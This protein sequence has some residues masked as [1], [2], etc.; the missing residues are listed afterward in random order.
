MPTN[1]EN[2]IESS[3]FF[4]VFE[5][6]FSS[7]ELQLLTRLQKT[8]EQKLP[9]FKALNAISFKV[10]QSA[11]TS[12]HENFSGVLLQSF[13]KNDKPA[14]SLKVEKNIIEVSCFVYKQWDNVWEEAQH[15][16]LESI[17]S[18]ESPSNKLV[19]CMLKVV[20]KFLASAGSYNIE[21]VFSSA[22]PYLTKNVLSEKSG[23]LWHVHEGWFEHLEAQTYLNALN[24]STADENG[25]IIT[26]IEHTV[27]CQFIKNPQFIS[28]FRNKQMTDIFLSLHDKN[29]VMLRALLNPDQLKRIGLWKD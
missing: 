19:V 7:A 1:H 23:Q 18:I 8:L 22:T 2:S 28:E 17:K 13:D 29:K 3:S 4:L 11:V 21:N 16:L 6:D 26:N 5:R 25:T 20:D 9:A 27:Q 24:L 15:Y 14:W 12:S 10:E